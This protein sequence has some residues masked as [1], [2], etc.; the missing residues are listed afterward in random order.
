[1]RIPGECP[2]EGGVADVGGGKSFCEPWDCWTNCR[3][4]GHCV[5]ESAHGSGDGQM[6]MF[7]FM[8]DEI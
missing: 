8:E 4:V 5:Y 7:D 6:T 1:M 2:D 3:E